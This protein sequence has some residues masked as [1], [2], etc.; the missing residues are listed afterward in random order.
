MYA[1]SLAAVVVILGLSA[2][3]ER[4]VVVHDRP[5]R[6]E[7]VQE[8]VIAPAPPPV[9]VIEEEPASRPNFVWVRGYYRWDGG[10]YAAVRG[11]W[12]P[13]RPGYHYVH[14]HW[15]QRGNQWHFHAG[16]WVAG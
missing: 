5:V 16:V 4:R 1:K 7:Y 12:E 6:R 8:E 2:C 10:R 13:A 11:H 3:V 9:E 14:P 15:E